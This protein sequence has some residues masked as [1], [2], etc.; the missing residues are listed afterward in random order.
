MDSPPSQPLNPQ[1]QQ[2]AKQTTKQTSKETKKQTAKQTPISK[3][4][5]DEPIDDEDLGPYHTLDPQS[6]DQW[7]PF[8][9]DPNTGKR[10]PASSD[11]FITYLSQNV[12]KAGK[13][14]GAFEETIR[15]LTNTNTAKDTEEKT[16]KGTDKKTAKGPVAKGTAGKTPAAKEKTIKESTSIS[17]KSKTTKK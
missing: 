16:A 8:R 13:L 5:L 11:S 1:A 15:S 7:R 3:E 17:K 4:G 14:K 10:Y 9:T 6:I 2:S 12:S